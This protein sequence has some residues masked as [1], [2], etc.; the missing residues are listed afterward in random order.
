MTVVDFGYFR[1]KPGLRDVVYDE[2][3]KVQGIIEIEPI[4]RLDKRSKDFD[5]IIET[6]PKS[7]AEYRYIDQ[8]ICAI[9]DIDYR[10]GPGHGVS[11]KGEGAH[12]DKPPLLWVLALLYPFITDAVYAHRNYLL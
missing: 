5:F 2:L 4:V 11:W 6:E 3:K 10:I 8:R 7:L 9:A 1:C 12:R